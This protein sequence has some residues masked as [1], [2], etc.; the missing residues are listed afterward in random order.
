[1]KLATISEK[2]TL[3]IKEFECK[4]G[5]FT[6]IKGKKG[7]GKTSIVETLQTFFTNKSERTVFVN[8]DSEKGEVLLTFDD[9]MSA[10]KT[11]RPAGGTPYVNIDKD[12]M[13]PKSPE[14]YLKS[15]ISDTQINP[16]SFIFQPVKEQTETVLNTIKMQL[17]AE[18]VTE[19]WGEVPEG[20]DTEKHALKVCKDIENLYFG[21]RTTVNAEVKSLEANIAD[22][23]AKL[24]DGY[25]VEKWR[26]AKAT[27]VMKEINE[28]TEHNK[29]VANCM[30]L[31]AQA[32]SQ[33]ESIQ[34][35]AN[36]ENATRQSK[37]NNLLEQVEMLK[38]QQTAA[39]DR[40]KTDCTA[41]DEKVSQAQK[42]LTDNK[43]IEIQ[44]LQD[45][46]EEIETMKGF[47]LSA[48][49]LFE[50]QI[51]LETKKTEVKELTHKIELARS[52]PSKLLKSA[53]MPIDGLGIDN[54]G[55]I[56]VNGRPIDSLSGGER[57]EMA[58]NIAKATAGPLK[59]I[60][61]NGFEALDS[62]SQQKFI[63][64]VTDDE[65][66]YIITCVADGELNV[67]TG[68]HINVKSEG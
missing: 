43:E 59:L 42:W 17:T 44:P 25:D 27:D 45:K 1:M 60:L 31:V 20:I 67:T 63:D 8:S 58:L 50:K 3:G 19:I 41:V 23:K 66:Q 55:N 7:A 65:Y 57:I 56:S 39:A 47:V 64:S 9:G 68:D 32:D 24:P 53:K 5:K 10:K 38:A 16:I 46:A 18:Q 26:D 22:L 14:K 13:K 35:V 34:A 11:Y 21:K 29:Y 28:A 33:K 62:A 4:P 37:I 12:G 49:D 48:D 15:L 40:V 54:S 2:G 6:L 51:R 36:A 52:E 30:M 61:I